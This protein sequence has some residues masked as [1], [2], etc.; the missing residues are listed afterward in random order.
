MP[1]DLL[2]AF[3]AGA[4]SF[5]APCVVP[6]LPAYVSYLGGAALPQVQADPHAFQARMVRGGLLFVVGFGV[7]FV[8]LGVAAGV[9]G[10]ATLEGQKVLVQRV[11]GVLIIAIG[12]ALLGLLPARL[13]ER[14][15]SLLGGGSGRRPAGRHPVFAPVALGLVF[16]TAW[17]PCVGPVLSA[18]LG[19]AAARGEALRGGLLLSAYAV[20]L[21][22][23]FVVCSLLVASFPALVRPLARFSVVVSRAA[24]VLMVLL[25]VL[26]VVGLYQSL[27][28]YLAQPFT[29]H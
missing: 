5:F 26:L 4:V 17:T 2:V 16:G 19:L 29:L 3:T 7:V 21:G 23:P 6:L 11:G 1:A 22:L 13:G 12:L 20:G 15:F 24:G 25:G 28:G 9:V 14:S 27:S 10:S 18:I 8:L